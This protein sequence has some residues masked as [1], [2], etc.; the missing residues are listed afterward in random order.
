MGKFFYLRCRQLVR[1]LGWIVAAA[2]IFTLGTAAAG[3]ALIRQQEESAVQQK[4]KVAICGVTGDPLLQLGVT[5]LKSLDET[6]FSVELM[7]MNQA[8]A[9][10]ALKEGAAD[11][12][13]VIPEGFLQAALNGNVLTLRFITAPGGSAVAQLF[14]EQITGVIAQLLLP[15]QKGS[16]G[17]YYALQDNGMEDRALTALNELCIEYV[18]LALLRANAYELRVLGVGS[19]LALEEYLTC[20][21]AVGLI[22]LLCLGFA[23]MLV[24]ADVS[25]GRMLAAKGCSGMMQALVDFGCL[26]LGMTTV[27]VL[28]FLGMRVA[29]VNVCLSWY[30]VLPVVLLAAG[31]GFFACSVARELISCVC[32]L[33]V[34]SAAMCFVSGC[35]YPVY[36][37]PVPLQRLAGWLPTGIC[38]EYL[39]GCVTGTETV[40]LLWAMGICGSILVG[41]AVWIR[42]RRILQAK[43]AMA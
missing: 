40:G 3:T 5:A 22:F 18:E 6:R 13:V 23:P 8:Q 27:V 39:A 41:G 31:M 7:T 20:G 9:M 21:L 1:I 43:E 42:R 16:Y 4:Y 38:R 19:G 15:A 24:Q 26:L 17:A 36:F 12:C 25:L 33:F 30:D 14:Q 37:F 10:R 28:I 29:G 32:L 2:V 35:M 11:A 34:S